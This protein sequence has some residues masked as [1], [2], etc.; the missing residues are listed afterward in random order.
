MNEQNP[1]EALPPLSD[2]AVERIE[3]SVFSEI[4]D[5][6]RAAARAPRARAARRRWLTGAGIA[7]AFVVGVCVTPPILAL[8]GSG[9]AMSTADGGSVSDVGAPAPGAVPPGAAADRSGAGTAESGAVQPG[10]IAG[11]GREIIATAFATLEVDDIPDAADALAALA[12]E[13]GGYVESTDLGRSGG[14]VDSS[15]PAAPGPDYGWIGIRVPSD[16]LAAVVDELGD[17]G[18]VVSSSIARQDVTDTAVDLRARVEATT[19]SVQRLT[20]L[21]EQ[22][23]SVSELIEAEVALTERQA[24]LESYQQQ[25][26]ALDDQVAMSSLQVQLTPASTATSADPAGFTDGLQAGW[27]GL[28][29]SLNAVVIAAGFVLP[30]V[31]VAAVIVVIVLLVRRA[32]AGARRSARAG[33]S[34]EQD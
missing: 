11:E 13:H 18:Q 16:D 4:A 19:A 7:A 34:P 12:D 3:R 14:D 30:W 6:P 8:T 26:A 28:I 10:E 17:T 15:L 25:L 22:S 24:Q 5:E 27:N 33:A 29:V 1:R 2:A 21:M 20:E 31:A 23:G 32:R 9:S